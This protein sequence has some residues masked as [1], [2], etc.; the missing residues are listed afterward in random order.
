MANT[1][2]LLGDHW[3]SHPPKTQNGNEILTFTGE[4]RKGQQ[5]LPKCISVPV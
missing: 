3:R 2:M 4:L 1:Y 5:I